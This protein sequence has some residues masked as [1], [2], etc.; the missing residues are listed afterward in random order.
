[1]SR[2]G[3]VIK[4]STKHNDKIFC[5]VDINHPCQI[6]TYKLRYQKVTLICFVP[7]TACVCLWVMLST[8]ISIRLFKKLASDI[9]PLAD[10]QETSRIPLNTTMH[11]Q[12]LCTSGGGLA[13]DLIEQ[14]KT[15]KT[16]NHI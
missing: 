3:K 7:F 10:F 9:I 6:R 15:Y 2:L 16:Q 14:K 4:S 11:S 13:K 5:L 1:M 8:S 12:T